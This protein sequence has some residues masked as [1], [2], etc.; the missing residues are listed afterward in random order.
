MD[1]GI[2]HEIIIAILSKISKE[3]ER[4]M[5]YFLATKNDRALEK[6]YK[7]W[8]IVPRGTQS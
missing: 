5:L 4:T 1:S 8:I 2:R 3:D 6:F 7:N